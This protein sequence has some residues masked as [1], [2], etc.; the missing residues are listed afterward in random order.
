MKRGSSAASLAERKRLAKERFDEESREL[1]RARAERLGAGGAVA[2]K[3]SPK[4]RRE[5]G[6]TAPSKKLKTKD[7]RPTSRRQSTGSIGTH[8]AAG[9]GAFSPEDEDARAHFARHG[10]LTNRRSS[11]GGSAFSSAMNRASQVLQESDEDEEDEDEEEA[12]R[13]EEQARQLAEAQAAAEAKAAAAKAKFAASTVSRR[14]ARSVSR[15]PKQETALPQSPNKPSSFS[16]NFKSLY[17][18]VAMIAMCYLVLV[19]ASKV[20]FSALRRAG[21]P[22]GDPSSGSTNEGINVC[23]CS[24]GIPVDEYVCNADGGAQCGSCDDYYHLKE[25]SLCAANACVCTNGFAVSEGA[26]NSDGAHECGG[27]H[28]G[29]QLSGISC[30]PKFSLDDVTKLVAQ[31]VEF[32]EKLEEASDM[33]NLTAQQNMCFTAL[34]GYRSLEKDA[35]KVRDALAAGVG[36]WADGSG[37]REEIEEVFGAFDDL[38]W[39][40]HRA[41]W[42]AGEEPELL[43]G[44]EEKSCYCKK[45]SIK[46]TCVK[47]LNDMLLEDFNEAKKARGRKKINHWDEWYTLFSLTRETCTKRALTKQFRRL[48]IHYHPDK[49]RRECHSHAHAMS[50]VIGAG[51]ELLEKFT[52]CG[53]K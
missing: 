2:K 16:K 7:S 21:K 10:T 47:K 32:D 13:L 12:K 9:R 31:K 38:S 11:A 20:D 49:H 53:S 14:R 30:V 33:P 1:A 51:R 19:V 18:L 26:C 39:K 8:A 52:D 48:Y 37:T 25:N 43:A 34:S 15:T 6:V 4:R 24:N 46:G 45:N 17:E 40:V 44:P 36:I 35:K 22:S 28:A 3:K 41:M 29:F 42:C 27:C 23:T 5:S 50:L